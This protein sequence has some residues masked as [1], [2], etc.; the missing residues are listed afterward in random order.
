M[1][2]DEK[3]DT[4]SDTTPLVVKTNEKKDEASSAAKTTSDKDKSVRE[5]TCY[6]CN[7]ADEDFA[8]Q[9]PVEPWTN[10]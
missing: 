3:K 9:G 10:Y 6:Y 1:P 8:G 5:E 4:T 7:C 2:S